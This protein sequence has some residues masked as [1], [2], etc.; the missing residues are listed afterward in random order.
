M[1]KFMKIIP[2]FALMLTFATST[3][4]A[5]NQEFSF[6]LDPGDLDY[7]SYYSKDDS[8][9]KAYVNT[10][11]GDLCSSDLVYYKVRNKAN[12]KYTNSKSIN[13]YGKITLTYQQSVSTGGSYR[14][15]A[16]QDESCRYSVQVAGTWTP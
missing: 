14:L 3:A 11:S 1:N 9:A 4:F 7:T 12:T 2:T 5:N 10:K 8:E 13:S 15:N 16:Q 6:S